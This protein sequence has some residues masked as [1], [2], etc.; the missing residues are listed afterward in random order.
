MNAQEII[1]LF[2]PVII[3][4]STPHGTGTG[5]YVKEYDMIITNNHV[6]KE[7]IDAVISGKLFEQ[8]SSPVLFNDPK[9][10]I[11]LIQ[12]PGGISFPELKLA[13]DSSVNDGDSVI[14]IGHPYGLSYTATEG[15]VSKSKRLHNGL[16]YIQIDAAINPGNSGGPLVNEKGQI[17]GMNTF[18][19]NNSNNLGFAL[20]AEYIIES[21]NEYKLYTGKIAVRCPSC[22]NVVTS[23]NID[24]EYCPFCG[25]KVDLPVLKKEDDY[26]PA[27]ANATIE[28]ILTDLGK[29]VKLSRRGQ[30]SWEIKE[31]S[32]TIYLNY[33]QNGF[34]AGDAFICRLPKMNIGA[35]YEFLLRE[36]YTVEGISFSVNNQDIVL[37]TFIYD[38]YLTH[39]T[40]KEIIH[41]LFI[42]A[43]Y[44]DDYLIQ[45]FSAL[46][47]VIDE[48]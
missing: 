31:A 15:I 2:H 5:F 3:Q 29:D 21:L 11:A 30:N 39:D 42:K 33:N 19:I 22:M 37:S 38:E 13:P 44:Y 32:A 48:V 20:P 40:G 14:A 25:A 16:N 18:I 43:D 36:N 45:N 26:K 41:N 1:G 23:E 8:V 12:P 35:I 9:Y 6:V 10:D 17:I 27:G 7:S 24:G 28:K 46:Q 47:R 34:I 4:I